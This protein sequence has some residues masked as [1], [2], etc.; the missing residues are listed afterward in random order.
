MSNF[1]AEKFGDV[2][3]DIEAMQLLVGYPSQ[4]YVV[5]VHLHGET[6]PIK[7]TAVS[8]ICP[9]DSFMAANIL[10]TVTDYNDKNIYRGSV[11]DMPDEYA[12][13]PA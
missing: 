1:L 12:N 8:D 13:L 4:P 6:R 3:A 10:I 5:N 2:A 11:R 9:K 7:N